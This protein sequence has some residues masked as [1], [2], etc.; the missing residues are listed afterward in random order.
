M[1]PSQAREELKRRYEQRMFQARDRQVQHYV[2]SADQALGDSDAVAA[3]NALRI[4]VSLSPDDRA[5]SE[6]LAEVQKQAAVQ[7][8][9]SYLEQAT[10]EER[11]SRWLAAAR[12]YARAAQ[13]KPN[14]Q[15]FERVAY[16]LLMAETD[17][18]TAVDYGKRAVMAAPDDANTRLTLAR[19]YLAAGLKQSALGEF[20]RAATLAPN[21]DTIKDWLRRLKRGES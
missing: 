5:L 11:D 8:A 15:V 20:E 2:S 4:A 10:Y 3:A 21:D 19:V 6:R 13:G 17:L 16:C 7:L 1:S 9:D 14:A 18:K 12:S